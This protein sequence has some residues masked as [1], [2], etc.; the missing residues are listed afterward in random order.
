MRLTASQEAKIV[1]ALADIAAGNAAAYRKLRL[2]HGAALAA[3]MLLLGVLAAQVRA[4]S[5]IT[6]E[7]LAGFGAGT[8][9]MMALH[10]RLALVKWPVVQRYLDREKISRSLPG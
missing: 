2:F 6:W 10:F 3:G 8:A 9:W 1:A 4:R 7:A 5:V